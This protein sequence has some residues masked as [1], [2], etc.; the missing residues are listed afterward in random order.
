MLLV[1]A[2]YLDGQLFVLALKLYFQR[3]QCVFNYYSQS[4]KYTYI[5][6]H[7]KCLLFGSNFNHNR[8]VSKSFSENRKYKI[9]QKYSLWQSRC[10]MRSQRPT[11][12]N[13]PVVAFCFSNAPI[14]P[15]LPGIETPPP[16]RLT[17]V[18]VSMLAMLKIEI[19]E[20]RILSLYSKGPAFKARLVKRCPQDSSDFPQ[21]LKGSNGTV[22]SVTSRPPFSIY[23]PIHMH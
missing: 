11:D 18:V 21:F 4:H 9:L 10:F 14:C 16:L 19:W 17:C 23:I 15:S 20:V 2:R 6:I 3:T 13:R 1:K 22:P 7:V 5:R 8:N 12:A